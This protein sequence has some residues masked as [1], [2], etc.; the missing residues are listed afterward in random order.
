[1]LI[2]NPQRVIIFNFPFISTETKG[3]A[4]LV[5]EATTVSRVVTVACCGRGV[6]TL[7]VRQSI[8][9]RTLQNYAGQATDFKSVSVQYCKHDALM[10]VNFMQ[11]TSNALFIKTHA[12]I[13]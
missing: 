2:Y 10:T 11:Y 5:G 7:P 4:N 12:L 3:G 8:V 9:Y 6:W 1:M 13:L